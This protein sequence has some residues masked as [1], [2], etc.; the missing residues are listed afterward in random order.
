MFV[1]PGTFHAVIFD[2]VKQSHTNQMINIGQKMRKVWVSEYKFKERE[3][4]A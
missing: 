4:S 1:N 2:K 3:H